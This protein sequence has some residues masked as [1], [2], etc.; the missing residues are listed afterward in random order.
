M[1]QIYIQKNRIGFGIGEYV[2]IKPFERESISKDKKIY[3]YGVK[4]VHQIKLKI[5]NELMSIIDNR[6]KDYENIIITGSFLEEGFNFKDIDIILVTE[7]KIKKET[8]QI[9]KPKLDIDIHSIL[10]DKESFQ[11]ALEID[12]LWRLMISK[13]VS[14]KRLAPMPEKKLEY[15]YLDAQLIKS[16]ILI[17][18][19]DYLTGK[20]KY[21]L[22][23][24]LMTIYLFIKNKKLSNES[25]EREIRKKFNIEIEDLKNNILDKNFLKE[26]KN[27][28][29]KLE[30]E[31]IKNASK[32]E[33]IN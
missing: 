21:K 12:P 19:F 31:I 28:Y 24:N 14:K 6:I 15:K 11:K 25:V 29:I 13:C 2:I 16:K 23:R 8:E 10:F 4:Y 3:F 9:I 27:F 30:N 5:I 32:K 33:Q 18:N 1:D 26:Y 20:E 17:E 7:N 22:A